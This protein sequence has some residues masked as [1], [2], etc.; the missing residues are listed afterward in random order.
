MHPDSQTLTWFQIFKFPE[1]ISAASHPFPGFGIEK[2][3]NPDCSEI[4]PRNN[5]VDE[6]IQQSQHF[7]SSTPESFRDQQFNT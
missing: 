1:N 4:N 7:N 2:G 6:N 5:I 3:C